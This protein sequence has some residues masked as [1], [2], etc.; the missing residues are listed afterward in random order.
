MKKLV[1]LLSLL[2]SGF[3]LQAQDGL[4][5]KFISVFKNGKSF[6]VK[7]GTVPVKD[8]VYRMD[9]LPKAL[10][11]T[12][13]FAGT[14]SAISQVISKQE[15]VDKSV[16]RKANSFFE[17]LYANKG[18]QVTLTTV[19]AKIIT[20]TIDDFDLPEEVNSFLQLKQAELTEEY[21][22]TY[23][24][25]AYT[26]PAIMLKVNSKWLSIDPAI[27]RMIEFADQPGKVVKSNIKVK[28]PVIKV[29][30]EQEG[31]QGLNLMYLQNGISWV[32]VYKLE[33]INDTEAT[34]KLQAEVSNEVEDI[35]NTD[36]SF[37][38][39][40]P[41]FQ[42]AND[43]ATLTSFAR[44]IAR[45][46]GYTMDYST[47]SNAG[48]P[49]QVMRED[50]VS[51]KDM[52]SVS[53][54]AANLEA[55]AAEDLYF[56]V[57]KNVDM[58]KGSRAHYP[59]FDTRVKI[60]HQ[61]ECALPNAL[62]EQVYLNQD[63]N[64]SFD[65]QYCNVYHSVEI[66]ND[67][68]NPWT[69]GAVLIVDAA[70]QRPLAQDMIKYTGKGL[71]SAVKLTQSPDVRVDEKAT[72][73]ASK[74]EIKARNQT[75]YEYKLVTVESVVTIHNAK[76]KAIDLKIMKMILGKC[77]KASIPYDSKTSV[78]NSDFNATD[79][80]SFEMAVAAGETKKYTYTYDVYVRN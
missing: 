26:P 34:L 2:S 7:E 38:V 49:A 10:F 77:K 19:D 45:N 48:I 33:L 44:D 43:P 40:V 75:N 22:V 59:L 71:S 41:N 21:G 8:H 23:S 14:T 64:F 12:L 17:L 56:Y 51:E 18:K 42:Y 70:T 28:Q 15:A 63:D 69:T 13:W 62:D 68:K 61:Y 35:K 25:Y 55:E 47:F 60:K 5:T 76:N 20:G 73:I 57:I 50:A 6:V 32:P 16:E 3:I 30:F 37:V 74:T 65:K 31:N 53:G 66:K 11:G 9:K 79:R 72:I 24:N 58:E 52:E 46:T 29:F 4:K 54:R 27:I 80:L 1:L 36:I 39:G 67:T 78:K